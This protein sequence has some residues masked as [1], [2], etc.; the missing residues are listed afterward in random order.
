ML[1]SH[2]RKIDRPG[3]AF[4]INGR[5]NMF[6]IDKIESFYQDFQDDFLDSENF[7]EVARLCEEWL[8]GYENEADPKKCAI[9]QLSSNSSEREND[10]R[11]QFA[12]ALAFC[13]PSA[14]TSR[15]EKIYRQ[16]ILARKAYLIGHCKVFSVLVDP[17]IT[18]NTADALRQAE[19]D[20][21]FETMLTVYGFDHHK[22]RVGAIGSDDIVLFKKSMSAFKGSEEEYLDAALYDLALF[23]YD[24][25]S[26]IHKYLIRNPQDEKRL[27][28]FRFSTFRE[29]VLGEPSPNVMFLRPSPGD[30]PVLQPG[31]LM[32]KKADFY[33]LQPLHLEK[34]FTTLL[35]ADPYDLTNMLFA[36]KNMPLIF[37][38]SAPLYHACTKKVMEAGFTA[39]FIVTHG[40]MMRGKDETV[41]LSEVLSTLVNITPAYLS[42]YRPILSRYLSGFTA[43][44]ILKAT[45]N[46]RALAITYKMTGNPEIIRRSSG[47]TKDRIFESDLGL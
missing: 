22:L 6:H 24:P 17:S 37:D 29:N 20:A 28:Q 42:F 18:I 45:S 12:L 31:E 7:Y 19:S 3:K 1:S 4:L 36:C 15:I 41:T 35:L 21:A 33:Q 39:S 16:Q 34:D 5:I 30:A 9:Q 38:Q 11:F 8:L 46:P 26:V 27:A 13:L 2:K 23:P 32:L 25:S 43:D 14:S 10:G 47:S 40:I 44:E